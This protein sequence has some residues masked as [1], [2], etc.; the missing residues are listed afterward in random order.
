MGRRGARYGIGS[1]WAREAILSRRAGF[2]LTNPA[3]ARMIPRRVCVVWFFRTVADR[4][5]VRTAIGYHDLGDDTH[6]AQPGPNS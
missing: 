1:E 2:G 3:T 6:V 4:P 5:P